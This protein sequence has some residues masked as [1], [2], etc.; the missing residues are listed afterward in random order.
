MPRYYEL[1]IGGTRFTLHYQE[2]TEAIAP[3]QDGHAVAWVEEEDNRVHYFWFNRG[4]NYV[5]RAKYRGKLG[6]DTSLVEIAASRSVTFANLKNVMR[7]KNDIRRIGGNVA[8]DPG[9]YHKI[10]T[11]QEGPYP[12]TDIVLTTVLLSEEES[13]NLDWCTNP[14]VVIDVET[15]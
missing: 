15:D 1:S 11:K 3:P 10:I 6:L 5:L 4:L 13:E 9:R 2:G 14:K 8:E 7:W 12:R